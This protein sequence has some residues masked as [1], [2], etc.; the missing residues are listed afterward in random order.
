MKTV[1][2]DIDGTLFD[3]KP[4]IIECLNDVL[5]CFGCEPIIT[6]EEDKYIGPSVKDS[7]MI[8]HGFDEEK[9]SKATRMYREK[10]V[11]KYIRK[12]I[13]YEGIS[14]VFNYLKSKEYIV[15]IA[16]MKT[17][18]QVDALLKI[19]KFETVFDH[20]ECARE[21]GGYTKLDMLNSIKTLYPCDDI[22]FV[23]DTN[24]DYKAAIKADVRFVY[25]E[26]GYGNIEGNLD[27]IV[28]LKKLI[29][30][31]RRCFDE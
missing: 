27:A 2:F 10:Y 3:T 9:A 28:S 12:S 23:G 24:G 7:F 18:K 11:E 1:I 8:Y 5:N 20:I 25:A 19:F 16:T 15:C 13:P 29:E 31:L 26:Y 30:Y 22:I 6:S 4:G 14:D 17:R 21:E